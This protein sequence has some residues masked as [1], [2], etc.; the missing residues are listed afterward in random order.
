MFIAV[1]KVPVPKDHR[2]AVIEAF[3]KAAPDM[4]RFSGYLGLEMWIDESGSLLAV[5]RWT[6]KEALDE[7]IK[8]PLFKD[9]HGNAQ[10]DA[11]QTTYY[12]AEV[13]G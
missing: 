13:I 1:N 9:H 7:Y 2:Q 6:T 3:K 10:S 11:A 5:S 8:N 4:K 12:E